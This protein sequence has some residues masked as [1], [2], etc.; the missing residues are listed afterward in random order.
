MFSISGHR[1]DGVSAHVQW[2]TPVERRDV[3]GHRRGLVGDETIVARAIA[4]EGVILVPMT[5]TGPFFAADLDV[6]VVTLALLCS[7]F[8]DP[9]IDGL[10]P[11]VVY[12]VPEGAV[13]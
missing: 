11:R 9:Q 12:A 1:W 13:A 3:A 10:P 5:E 6:G 8:I 2:W 4:D 7:Y